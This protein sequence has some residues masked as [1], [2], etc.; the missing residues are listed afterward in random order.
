MYSCI[1]EGSVRH[2]RLRPVHHELKSRIWLIYLDL[3]EEEEVFSRSRLWS[4][5]RPAPVRYRRQDHFGAPN[6]PLIGSVREF[7]LRESGIEHR[8]PIRML[9]QLRQWG[10]LFNPVSFF[11]CFKD[12]QREDPE[13]IIA[14]VNNTPWRQRHC[15]LIQPRHFAHKFNGQPIAKEFHVSPFMDMQ[16]EYLWHLPP[17]ADRLKVGIINQRGEDRF[18]DVS[19]QL[20][21]REITSSRIA[22]LLVRYP[23]MTLGVMAQIYF[24]AFRLWAKRVPFVPHPV[25]GSPHGNQGIVNVAQKN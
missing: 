13:F 5:D 8:G 20:Q 9:T 7:V 12:A 18:F 15:Y 16:M 10:Y 3:D 22:N 17:P 23:L 14:E 4:A 19:M 25:K 21:R 11:Y 6:Q 2:R 1:Y 24:H